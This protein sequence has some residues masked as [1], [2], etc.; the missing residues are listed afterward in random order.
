MNK[1]LLFLKQC[2]HDLGDSKAGQKS[3]F[4]NS[5]LTRLLEPSLS[6][7][8]AVAVICNM[9]PVASDF[10]IAIDTLEF[11]EKAASINLGSLEKNVAGENTEFHKLQELMA[12]MAADKDNLASELGELNELYRAQI[13]EAQKHM[14]SASSIAKELEV[15]KMARLK[16]EEDNQETKRMLDETHEAKIRLEAELQATMNAAAARL[17]DLQAAEASI[18]EKASQILA[19]KDLQAQLESNVANVNDQLSKQKE[20]VEIAEAQIAQI[21]EENAAKEE[22][23]Q[24][25]ADDKLALEAEA[26][27][28]QQQLQTSIRAA[29]AK[30][31]EL[32]SLSSEK[33]ALETAAAEREAQLEASRKEAA[34]KVTESLCLHGSLASLTHLLLAIGCQD[35]HPRRPDK[36]QGGRIGCDGCRKGIARASRCGTRRPAGCFHR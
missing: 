21:A 6:G 11:G 24:S 26:Q 29:E 27:Q 34:E 25:L 23:L 12:A 9:T 7:G 2:I 1:S 22:A 13:E 14:V 33:A 18:E 8:A 32:A 36:G 19:A 3:S 35:R 20:A 31:K 17:A 30:D 28:T 5:T 4:R 15:E 10:K 16:L